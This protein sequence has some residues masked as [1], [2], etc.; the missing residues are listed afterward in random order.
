MN[1]IDII[2]TVLEGDDR[3]DFAMRSG[4]PAI[5]SV[6]NMVLLFNRKGKKTIYKVVNVHWVTDVDKRNGT[7][8]KERWYWSKILNLYRPGMTTSYTE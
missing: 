3:T 1:G 4:W 7:R 6:G 8:L 2:F 5:P